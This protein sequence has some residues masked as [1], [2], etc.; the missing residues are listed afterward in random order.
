M[1]IILFYKVLRRKG[2]NNFKQEH[3]RFSGQ[4]SFHL[5]LVQQRIQLVYAAFHINLA[6]RI[7][8]RVS[9]TSVSVNRIRVLCIFCRLESASAGCRTHGSLLDYFRGAVG[10]RK[11]LNVAVAVHRGEIRGRIMTQGAARSGHGLL[12]VLK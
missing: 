12:K 3:T 8:S 2:K 9:A 10:R 5:Q 4:I 11:V 7:V 1:A 6:H